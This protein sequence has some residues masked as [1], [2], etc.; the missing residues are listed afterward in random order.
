M[1]SCADRLELTR[2]LWVLRGDSQ[3]GWTAL[4]AAANKGHDNVVL[5]LLER[6]ATV[7]HAKTVSF[8]EM[9]N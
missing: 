2:H 3:G 1:C 8:C 6:G 7:N 4:M 9:R 5:T